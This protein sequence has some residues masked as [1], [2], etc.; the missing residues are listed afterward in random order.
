MPE[1][2]FVDLGSG[3]NLKRSVERDLGGAPGLGSEEV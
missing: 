3:D 2:V 1:L